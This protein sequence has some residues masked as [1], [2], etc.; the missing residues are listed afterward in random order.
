MENRADIQQYLD[1]IRRRKF[2]IVVPAIVVFIL[3]ASLALLLPPVYKATATIMVESQ[4]IPK[5]LVR[6]AV[7]GYVEERLQKIS[8]MV[9][10]RQS[11]LDVFNR[12][13]INRNLKNNL[14]HAEAVKKFR[15]A[16]KIEPVIAEVH[17]P[18]YWKT[19]GTTVAFTLSYEG[20]EAEKVAQ[21][22]NYLASLL[23]EADIKDR[24]EK[25]QTSF[26]FLENQAKDLRAEILQIEERVAD[27]KEKHINEL[28]ELMQL[29]VQTMEKLEMEINAKQE[30]IKNLT[31]RKIY[32]EG[33]LATIEPTLYRTSQEGRRLLTPKE[34]LE[35]LRNQ[36]LSLS[37]SFSERHPDVITLKKKL[38]AMERKV[39]TSEDLHQHQ[40]EL[41]EKENRLALLSENY[42]EKYPDV[43][44]LK[45]EVGLLKEEIQRLA[46]T[47]AVPKTGNE[48]P[49]NPAYIN[50]QTQIVSTELEIESAKKE[51]ELIKQKYEDYRR[52]VENTPR[53][54]KKYL[55][56]QRNYANAKEKYD[57]IIDRLMVAKEAKGL[58]ESRRGEKFTLV[59]PAI[60]PE[61]AYKPNRLAILLLGVVLAAGSG[62]GFGSVSEYMDHSMHRADELAKISGHTVLAVVPYL[63]TSQDSLQKRRRIFAFSCGAISLLI[64]GLAALHFL[65]LPLDIL[66]LK[67]MDH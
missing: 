59:E 43:V 21:V 53:V 40:R 46:A 49:E 37:A 66:W 1:V 13:G 44:R 57:K 30:N 34:E 45:K 50:I 58:E 19:T 9:F 12:F 62:L 31:N 10:S 48:K 51:L 35:A 54:E 28:P 16:I 39:S 15:N 7:T 32:L 14:T 41:E 65:Y 36:Y 4:E 63:K 22:T 33:Q 38:A 60:A 5:D 2:H 61:K 23:L 56:L 26:E 20:K 29:N 47:Q 55:D 25:A 67:F 52:R 3:A 11:L 64:I 8:G 17:N 6:G 24:G 18:T 27:Y 42:S